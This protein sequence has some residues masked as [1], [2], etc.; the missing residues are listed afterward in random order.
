MN[1]R[2]S[3]STVLHVVAGVGIDCHSAEVPS[4]QI[5]AGRRGAVCSQLDDRESGEM[6]LLPHVGRPSEQNALANQFT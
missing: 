4:G 2:S 5:S 6:I 1:G 3:R